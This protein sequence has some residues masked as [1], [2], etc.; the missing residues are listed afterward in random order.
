LRIPSPN[1]WYNE[2]RLVAVIDAWEKILRIGVPLA[3]HPIYL[4]EN[5]Q[6][7]PWQDAYQDW[8]MDNIGS[9]AS[10]ARGIANVML[11]TPQLLEAKAITRFG[12]EEVERARS[13][14]KRE[15]R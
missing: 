12:E 8:L 4:A 11:F 6:S 7:H 3:K 13:L 5:Y 15:K 14:Y 9:R 2:N 10:V 1:Q